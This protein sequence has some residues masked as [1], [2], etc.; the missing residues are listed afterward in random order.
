[1]NTHIFIASYLSASLPKFFRINVNKEKSLGNLIFDDFV[2]KQEDGIPVTDRSINYGDGCF[3]TMYSEGEHVFLID[4]HIDRLEHDANRLG[5]KFCIE[6]LKNYLYQACVNLLNSDTSASAIKVL[7]SRG[8]GGRGYEPPEFPI[9]QIIISFYPTTRLVISKNESIAYKKT[10][11]LAQIR[12]SIQPLL[13]GIKH[14][15]RLEQVL[16]KQELQLQDCDDLLI[17]NQDDKLIEATASNIFYLKSGVWITPTIL[18][19]G[20]SGVMRNSILE[21]MQ[22][23]AIPCEAQ[24]IGIQ[25]ILE[26][27]SV[28]L[29]NSIKFII[30]ISSFYAQNKTVDFNIGPSFETLDNVYKWMN[31]KVMSAPEAMS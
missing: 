4:K 27:E 16:A 25:D 9:P 13:A 29:C 30:P 14:L 8:A 19:S 12:L 22:L 7:I 18:D 3:T 5:I 17:C 31:K 20:V 2:C 10:V 26:A 24:S 23:N 21:F 28:F 15:N 6:T 11:K 1:M